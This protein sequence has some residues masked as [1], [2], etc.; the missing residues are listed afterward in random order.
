MSQDNGTEGTEPLLDARE[1]EDEYLSQ[2][3]VGFQAG[4]E[5]EPRGESQSAGWIK[6]WDDAQ[7]VCDE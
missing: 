5:G 1:R 3:E 2:R 6:S 7:D 4:I